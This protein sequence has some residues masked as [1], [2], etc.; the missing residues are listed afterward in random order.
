MKILTYDIGTSAVKL[1]LFSETGLL[2]SSASSN[3]RTRVE[4]RRV[5]QDPQEWWQKFLSCAYKCLL[6]GYDGGELTIVGTGQMEDLI[7][8]DRKG[9]PLAEAS[10]YSDS[11]IG[12]YQLPPDWKAAIE[13]KIPNQL[14]DF[15]P[16]VKLLYL[17]FSSPQ[18]LSEAG[19]ILFGAKD[20][21]NFKLTGESWTDPTNAATTGLFDFRSRAWL[22][23]AANHFSL[24]LLPRLGQ[25]YKEIGRVKPEVLS[26][27]GVSKDNSR[28]S[29]LNGVGDLGAV[30]LGAGVFALGDSYFYLGTTGWTAVLAGAVASRRELFSLAG[31][32]EGEWVVVA[33]LLNLGN[34][35]DW[36]LKTF[37]KETDYQQ[38]ETALRNNIEIDLQVWPYLNGERNPYRNSKLRSVVTRITQG[39]TK[40]QLFAAYVRSLA[41]AL[42]H[43]FERLG[44]DSDILRLTGGLSR[45]E[46]WCQLLSDVFQRKGTVVK[47]E[48]LV[49]QKGLYYLYLMSK[50]MP[51]PTV[52]IEKVYY[53]QENKTL[54]K[55]Y[56]EYKQLAELLLQGKGP[57][58]VYLE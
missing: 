54:E 47:D 1:S 21:I 42:R 38:G 57:A 56:Q 6:E 35:Y 15:T 5:T 45:L 29:V 52:E 58:S 44:V 49:P 9:Y 26:I 51:L 23:E 13:K 55:L 33:P 28:L 20:Y 36:A 24:D 3:L 10:L 14:D 46:S 16:L 4:G 41:F 37:L 18:I 40:E 2:L 48:T 39:T 31:F 19:Y 53:P 11:N 27:F 8:L 25:P 30:T 32:R 50:D 34:V 17:S 43:V 22:A 7:L 12:N